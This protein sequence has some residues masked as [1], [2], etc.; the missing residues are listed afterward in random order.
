MPG[1]DEQTREIA[2]LPIKEI[3][4]TMLSN[5]TNDLGNLASRPKQKT[6]HLVS[7]PSLREGSQHKPLPE[8]LDP[9]TAGRYGLWL[10]GVRSH[11]RALKRTISP[12]RVW[13]YGPLHRLATLLS[14]WTIEEYPGYRRFMASLCGVAIRTSDR[15]FY[16]AD[17]LPRKHARRL[18]AI[19]VE[20]A[21]AYEALAKEFEAW[22]DRPVERQS[23]ER[24]TRGG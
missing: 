23:K 11:N 16:G 10:L 3:K 7:Q 2:V 12:K 17:R 1:T 4:G 6:Q 9:V 18:A 8:G 15:W 24:N 21:A 22:A 13:G 5:N 20:R 14:P 19:C